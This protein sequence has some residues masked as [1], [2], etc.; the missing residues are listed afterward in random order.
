MDNTL[1]WNA[2][3]ALA[4]ALLLLP[5]A[6][7]ARAEFSREFTFPA[8]DLRIANLIGQV[9][10]RTHTG[11]E[12][13]VTIRV[14]GADATEARMRFDEK[15]GGLAVQFPLDETR[16]FVYPAIGR[17]SRTTF[18]GNSS[19]D[20]DGWL[21]ELLDL[22]RG[23]IEVRGDEWSDALEIWADVSVE[24]PTGSNIRVELG[25]GEMD[26]TGVQ[27]ASTCSRTPVPWASRTSRVRC[28]STPAAAAWS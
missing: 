13:R 6:G 27:G 5:L 18:S 14:R 17:R 15:A 8:G 2:G 28:T 1:R 10:V 11:S 21:E 19:K 12:Y 24:V 26:A 23:R 7:T 22:G 9:D 4:G 3:R 25:V 16:R 20:H